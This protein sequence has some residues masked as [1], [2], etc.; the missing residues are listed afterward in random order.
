[1]FAMLMRAELRAAGRPVFASTPS[2]FFNGSSASTRRCCL[3]FHH[4]RVRGLANFVLP[5]MIG[6]P[7]WL[8]AILNARR[9]WMLPLAGIMSSCR[10]RRRRFRSPAAGRVRPAVGDSAESQVFFTTACSSRGASL[11]RGR[12]S[13]PRHDHH[14]ARSRMSF[15]GC[16][17]SC[18]GTFL[19]PRCSS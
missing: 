14:D 6:A 19:D 12:R 13:T 9:F 7:T 3:P 15:S 17:C 1:L 8:S 11:E 2:T 18:G 16:R 4:P 10:S 5:L